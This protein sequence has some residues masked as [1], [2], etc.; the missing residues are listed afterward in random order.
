M[1]DVVVWIITG[2][3]GVL[4]ATIGFLVKPI[5]SYLQNLIK[6][7]KGFRKDVKTLEENSYK[8][9]RAQVGG[10]V[11]KIST[12]EEDLKRQ[13]DLLRRTLDSTRMEIQKG[14]VE[15]G[16]ILEEQRRTSDK[17][18][19]AKGLFELGGKIILRHNKQLEKLEYRAERLGNDILIL[20]GKK[21]S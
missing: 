16:E 8:E 14:R 18:A 2:I 12:L 11:F 21:K 19:K 1:D 13:L 7:V 10:V 5:V 20:K 9:I 6:E 15:L 3:N 17:M 4:L